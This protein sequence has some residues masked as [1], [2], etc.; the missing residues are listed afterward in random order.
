MDVY[1][2]WYA[3]SVTGIIMFVL[4]PLFGLWGARV[5]TI[6]RFGGGSSTNRKIAL[7]EFA[8]A[9]RFYYSS[10]GSAA[11]DGISLG[12]NRR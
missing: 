6:Y 11:R 5:W 9:I 10:Y 1:V 8:S 2:L 4:A 7:R 12:G 3:L